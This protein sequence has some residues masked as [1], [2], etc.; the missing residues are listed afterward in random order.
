MHSALNTELCQRLGCAVP[1]IQTGMGW[2][3]TPD[4]VVAVGEA[5]GF[6]FLAAATLTP[7]ETQEAVRDIKARTNTP[8]GVNFHLFQPGA[9][10]IADIVIA[11]GV[12]AVGYS[13]AP[14]PEV[15]ERFRAK[16][17]ICMPTVGA[18]RHAQKAVSLGADM[19]IA[20]GGEGGGHT[21]FVPTSL[22]TSQVARQVSV[23]VAAAGGFKDGRGLVAALALGAQGVA[24]GTRFL[25]TQESPA[26]PNVQERYLRAALQEIPVVVRLDGL[27]HRMI[28]N[29]FVEGLEKKSALG[30]LRMAISHG[31]ALRKLTGASV[32]DMVRAAL[33]LL[34]SGEQGVAA[35]LMAASAPVLIR[36]AMVEGQEEDGVLPS[37]QVA[38]II[39]DIPT[40]AA[41]IDSITQEAEAVLGELNGQES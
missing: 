36:R 32:G 2:V 13:R 9:Q 7:E 23:P 10:D 11:E 14:Q 38:G 25:L 39:E 40:C 30:L 4:L 19:L 17:V 1:I 16:G 28:R 20:Q 21:G 33:A 12:R 37:G 31:F 3:A 29:R 15:I 26:P 41:L 8:F 35:T 6:G 18:P 34:R 24:M 27:P 22:L 5:G